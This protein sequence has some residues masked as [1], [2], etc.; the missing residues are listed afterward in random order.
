M[1][2]NWW[3]RS[4]RILPVLFGALAVAHPAFADFWPHH[5]PQ[6]PHH[7]PFFDAPEIDP[8]LAIAGLAAA[9]AA[10]AIVWERVRRRR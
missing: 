7:D 3:S 6:Y 9:G 2:R 1:N 8:A 10:V 4:T 5:W